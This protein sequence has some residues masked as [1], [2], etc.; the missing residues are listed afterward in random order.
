MTGSSTPTDQTPLT[1]LVP[2]LRPY[3]RAPWA[4]QATE[5]F[6]SSFVLKT[7]DR[8]V[9]RGYYDGLPAMVASS[10]SGSSVETAMRATSMTLFARRT[11]RRDLSVEAMQ[12]YGAAMQR[13]HDGLQRSEG[14]DVLKTSIFLLSLYEAWLSVFPTFHTGIQLTDLS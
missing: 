10:S 1:A 5:L 2:L 3:L 7:A 13:L 8:T 9:S 12:L 14:V 11:G 4:E 6:F